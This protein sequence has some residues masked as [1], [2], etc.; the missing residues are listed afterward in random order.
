MRT[1]SARPLP[2]SRAEGRATTASPV[3]TRRVEISLAIAMSVFGVLFS[4]QSLPALIGQWHAVSSPLGLAIIVLVYGLIALAGLAAVLR[5]WTRTAFAAAAVAYLVALAVWP[6]VVAGA[7]LPPG[8]AP[9]IN[10][11]AAL[12]CGFLIVARRHWPVPALYAALTSTLLGILRTTPSGGSASPQR[13]LL[14]AVYA[15]A[16]DLG[17]LILTVAVR[18]AARSVDAAQEAAL[19][20][21]ASA[22]FDQATEHERVQIDA[23]VHDRVLTTFLMAAKADTPDG[24]ARAA[25]LA[26]TAIAELHTAQARASDEQP[27]VPV[28]EILERIGADAGAVAARFVL[29]AEGVSGESVPAA[30]AEAL[31]AAAVQAMVN[32]INH[33]GDEQVARSV[34]LQAEQ[35]A[36]VLT[37]AD[38][39]AGFDPGAVPRERLGVRVSIGERV[40][41]VRGAA[42]VDSAPGRGTR[43]VLVWPAA[44]ASTSLAPRTAEAVLA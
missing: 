11:L 38:R 14:D 2:P 5:Q 30:V 12:A 24:E 7:G 6:S 41:A 13:A 25:R 17:L 35:G 34:R 1:E 19:E 22:E 21:Y 28:A 36:V 32:S 29:Q 39:G 23:L 33:A 18:Q 3:G 43:V 27:P 26:A 4:L 9:W 37:V 8:D 20:T 42:I 15:F 16:L 44:A 10:V 40:R 31:V